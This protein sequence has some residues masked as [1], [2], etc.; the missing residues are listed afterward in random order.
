VINRLIMRRRPPKK[1]TPK[2]PYCLPSI[3]INDF[4]PCDHVDTPESLIE[5]AYGIDAFFP[6]LS[7]MFSEPEATLRFY[8]SPGRHRLMVAAHYVMPQEGITGC[9][10]IDEVV[11]NRDVV[12]RAARD[13]DVNDECTELFYRRNQYA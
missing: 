6:A 9:V 2:Q 5:R 10:S 12:E 8:A 4:M 3:K 1:P 11:K 13:A 7:E